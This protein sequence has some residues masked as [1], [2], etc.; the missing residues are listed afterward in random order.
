[1]LLHATTIVVVESEQ[2]DNM[3]SI[4]GTCLYTTM[5]EQLFNT[6]IKK[7]TV[8]NLKSVI[9][10]KGWSMEGLK[11]KVDFQKFIITSSYHEAQQNGIDQ[12]K[13]EL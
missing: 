2:L 13:A 4:F 6:D 7:M 1:M 10:D 8:A 12:M 9:T 5:S 3:F 11:R